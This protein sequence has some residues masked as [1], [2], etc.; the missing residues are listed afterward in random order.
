MSIQVR[1]AL[2]CTLEAAFLSLLKG[3]QE[4]VEDGRAGSARVASPEQVALRTQ[5]A[6]PW[7]LRKRW[8]RDYKERR[9]LRTDS[10]RKDV[11]GLVFSTFS[12]KL[13]ISC[14][15]NSSAKFSDMQTKLNFSN[16]H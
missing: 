8:A 13:S 6:A 7:K 12:P 11:K 10:F 1:A 2:V 15:G 5:D 16:R 4:A 14:P 3:R 9:L